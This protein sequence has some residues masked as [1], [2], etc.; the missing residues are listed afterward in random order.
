MGTLFLYSICVLSSACS[1][2]CNRIVSSHVRSYDESLPKSLLLFLVFLRLFLHWFSVTA[3]HAY[4]RQ[5]TRT[6]ILHARLFPVICSTFGMS[7]RRRR[8][9]QQQQQRQINEHN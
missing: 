5:T 1:F 7:E 3:T 2:C 4:G 8:Q 9:Q 6:D